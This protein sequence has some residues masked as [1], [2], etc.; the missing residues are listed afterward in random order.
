M[1]LARVVRAS[2]QGERPKVSISLETDPATGVS[3]ELAGREAPARFD[4]MRRIVRIGPLAV[5]QKGE[6][7]ARRLTFM[8]AT[9]QGKHS[10]VDIIKPDGTVV[11]ASIGDQT[12]SP[13][14][15]STNL[16]TNDL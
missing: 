7:I 4:E 10:R 5:G 8:D 11:A 1:I 12:A 13:V 16:K 15:F 9:G 14:A 6:L 3:W 2:R